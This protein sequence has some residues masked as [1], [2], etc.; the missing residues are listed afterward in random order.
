[1]ATQKL[2]ISMNT[3]GAS[4]VNNQ[5]NQIISLLKQQSQAI[6]R[7]NAKAQ[8]SFQKTAA[9]LHDVT[10]VMGSV[11]SAARALFGFLSPALKSA[12][13]LG[14][15]FVRSQARIGFTLKAVGAETQ[16]ATKQ[17]EDFAFWM[18]TNTEASVGQIQSLQSVALALNRFTDPKKVNDIVKASVALQNVI[19]NRDANVLIGQ[20]SQSL[21]GVRTK[22]LNMIPAVRNLTKEQLKQG[23]AIEVVNQL[24]A[25]GG[26]GSG[27]GGILSAA[28]DTVSGRLNNLITITKDRWLTTLGRAVFE[29]KA[30]AKG[31]E[32]LGNSVEAL[33]PS[34]EELMPVLQD[35][36]VFVSKGAQSILSAT[37][38]I[39]RSF[40]NMAQGIGEIMSELVGVVLEPMQELIDVFVD[41]AEATGLESEFVENLDAVSETIEDLIEQPRELGNSFK[42]AA[43]TVANGA[44]KIRHALKLATDAVE[45]YDAA[46][47]AANRKAVQASK[48]AKQLA[49]D[50]RKRQEKIARV[51]R[52]HAL[53]YQNLVEDLVETQRKMWQET[54]NIARHNLAETAAEM[55]K[56]AQ[57]RKKTIIG[58]IPGGDFVAAMASGDPEQQKDALANLTASAI[59]GTIQGIGKAIDLAIQGLTALKDTFV[60]FLQGIADAEAFEERAKEIQQFLV[61][62]VSPENFRQFADAF[63]NAIADIFKFLQD[64]DKV[65]MLAEQFTR[66]VVS[67]IGGISENIGPILEVLVPAAIDIVVGVFKGIVDN[68]GPILEA[69]VPAIL[70]IVQALFELL[71]TSD[72]ISTLVDAV[73]KLVLGIIRVILDNL[74]QIV[75]NLVKAVLNGIGDFIEGIIDML[76]SPGFIAK[77]VV[78]I[79]NLIFD[80]IEGIARLIDRIVFAILK[81]LLPIVIEVFKA[82]VK[83]IAQIFLRGIWA[84]LR[85]IIRVASFG[86]VDIGD[87]PGSGADQAVDQAGEAQS[88][89]YGGILRRRKAH[90]GAQLQPGEETV[91]QTDEAIVVPKSP[92][93]FAGMS[94]MSGGRVQGM[95]GAPNITINLYT[96]DGQS[97]ADWLRRVG[98]AELI[99]AVLR[100]MTDAEGRTL[101]GA[102]N[103]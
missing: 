50:E 44:D 43:D 75:S 2:T 82:V 5:L 7:G 87:A 77:F 80:I 74:P 46:Q 48:M 69:L 42:G 24:L 38:V 84:I 94:T 14:N 55:D 9:V 73:I 1:M 8:S 63:F 26:A 90:N 83:A 27:R 35:F 86:T 17:L 76:A 103:G 64:E 70:R 51:R 20:L 72:F 33:A 32:S 39:V 88:M 11:L 65:A 3:T 68:L 85:I 99:D 52:K 100:G 28:V 19:P 37:D 62:I 47:D 102:I 96:M 57:E 31:L 92:R 25:G 56:R 36:F 78:G 89:H 34:V 22:T 53:D 59:E 18:S 40:G 81:N 66:M 29:N 30:L 16:G 49:E 6:E 15:E 97:T 71:A 91:V 54:S 95:G 67:V 98:Y 61:D 10:A 45:S 12:A 21:T 101:A 23:K 13:E 41:A 4:S 60:S 93:Q 79:V 58:A